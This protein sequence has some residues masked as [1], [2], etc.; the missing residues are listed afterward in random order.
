MARQNDSVDDTPESASATT[1]DSTETEAV[2]PPAAP[3]PS[4]PS[5]ARWSRVAEAVTVALFT[6]YVTWPYLRTDR[7]V[8]GFDTATYGGPHTAFTFSELRHGRFP[9]WNDALFGGVPHLANPQAGV[10]YPLRLPFL[11]MNPHRA[12]LMMTALHVFIM[13]F[14]ML[15]LA[16]QLRYRAPA[17]ALMAIAIAGSG[18]VMNRALSYEQLLPLA[19]VPWLL[20]GID[21]LLREPDRTRRRRGIVVVSLITAL[22]LTAGHPQQVY[23]AAPFV[24]L[25]A[26]VRGVDHRALRRLRA[27]IVAAIAG[28]A[29]CAIALLP[30]ARLLPNAAHVGSRSLS[31]LRIPGVSAYPTL[32][33]GTLFGDVYTTR[34]D[35]ISNT[36][37]AMTYVGVVVFALA[38]IGAVE[39]L[40]RMHA[41]WTTIGLVV[42]SIV[43]VLLSFGPRVVL[44]RIAFRL[45]PGFDVARVP[46]R[47]LALTCFSA[48]LLA[49]HGLDAL[50]R[51]RVGR[52]SLAV[53]ATGTALTVAVLAATALRTP[54]TRVWI[55]WSGAA[56]LVFAAVALTRRFPRAATTACIVLTAAALLELGIPNRHSLARL[57]L[58]K[59][60]ITADGGNVT[61]FLRGQPDRIFTLT[62]DRVDQPA[63]LVRA[64]RPNANQ[65]FTIRQIDGYDGGVQVLKRWTDTMAQLTGS[66]SFDIEST[67]RVQTKL[68]VDTERLARLGVRWTLLETN[69]RDPGSF[70]GPWK[71][72]EIHDDTTW[73]FENPAFTSSAIAYYRTEV[74][75]TPT[76]P[77]HVDDPA[78]V[79]TGGP[80]LQCSTACDASPA[81]ITRL[82]SGAVNVEVDAR[83]DAVVAIAEQ[84]APG[85]TAR[86]DGKPVK[87]FAVDGFRVATSVPAGSHRI[88]FRY[89]APGLRL[90]ELVSL[91]TALILLAAFVWPARRVRGLHFAGRPV[92]RESGRPDR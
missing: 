17:G 65:F 21:W 1:P 11:W 58:Q 70:L 81:T 52:R 48:V 57:L 61:A 16:W 27:P 3:S 30:A 60:P 29:L 19:W 15:V 68:P 73:L 92:R 69:G 39:G 34:P 9:Q 82:H 74:A 46:A 42:S 45:V 41:R 23:I 4:P 55:P 77:A 59:T 10:F 33:A 20:A 49:G 37:E 89:R 88:E 24:I 83:A 51:H 71:R 53:L 64:M 12:I 80:A 31:D 22:L 72:T 84:F 62:D 26:V 54:E 79:E 40:R 36:N 47:W 75:E 18:L 91:V 56:L 25:W 86:V 63:Y 38:A 13:A 90:G 50:A 43:G 2:R 85:W 28:A 14:G 7:W 6:L 44:F 78:V 66:G 5:S 8:T 87:A 32:T 67:F 76:I 35:L